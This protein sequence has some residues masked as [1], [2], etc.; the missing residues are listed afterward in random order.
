ML[1]GFW[2][3]DRNLSL[4]MDFYELTMA[5]GYFL[6][7]M[8]QKKALFEFFFRDIPDGGGFAIAAGLQQVV[9]AVCNLRFTVSDLEYL[10]SKKMF[11]EDFL[12][13]LAETP[14]RC[15]IRA[16]PEG[17]PIFPGEPVLVVEGPLAQAQMVES[18]LLNFMNHQSLIA[19]KANRIV[20]AAQGRAVME[21]G[22]RRAHGPDAAIY[23]AR[24]A[25]IG[26]CIG[27][28]C[29]LSDSAMG[30]PAMGT[31]AHSWIQS[32]PDELSA[33]IAYAEAYPDNCT[34]LIDTYHVVESGL[35]NA[36]RAFQTVVVPKGYRPKGVRIDSGDLAYL[37]KIVRGALDGAGFP[38]CAI[39]ASN[40]LDEDI[41]SDLILQGAPIDFFGVGERLITAKSD[42]VFGGVYKLAAIEE[43]GKM[44]PRMKVSENPEKMT[45]PGGKR[46]F[47]L[48]DS[49]THKAMAD[50]ITTDDPDDEVKA[51]YELFD[52]DYTWK[53]KVVKGFVAKELLQEVVSE[54]ILV[55]EL[56]T[57][58]EI[59]A[60]C[61]AQIDLLWDEV[62][63]FENPHKYWVDLSPRL[64]NLRNKLI[65]EHS[66]GRTRR[67]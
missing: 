43:S 61:L 38:D 60:Y 36:V 31:M 64:W 58:D 23:G 63:R 37:S 25:Y 17:T 57:L 45:L 30:V 26:G 2:T 32:F 46:L 12:Q 65:Q 16:V 54:G 50:L 1:N 62:K 14:F 4:L 15:S 11:S 3:D 28:A 13:W 9:D 24:A 42:P 19:T 8:H 47:R 66:G 48:F 10:R 29:T 51:P 41:I 59:R 53:R 18:M 49:K 44:S 6:Q 33:F 22:T 56:P 5:N 39:V 40:A 55:T 27:T 21:F 52:P 20:R 7:S 35:P 34:L 67:K